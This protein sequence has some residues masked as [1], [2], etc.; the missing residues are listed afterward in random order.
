MEALINA[1]LHANLTAAISAVVLVTLYFW[2]VSIIARRNK[3]LEALS[4][5]DAQLKNRYE[6]IPNILTI[7]KKFMEHE[8]KIF[9]EV[10]KLRESLGQG[11][12]LKSPKDVKDHLVKS[13]KLSQVM[14]TFMARAESYPELKS[15]QNMLQAQQSYNEIEAQILAARRFYNSAVGS[16]RDSVQVFP[17]NILAKL[18]GVKEMP[19]YEVDE[20]SK[21]SVN[22][23]NFL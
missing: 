23:S 16:L 3:V 5:I 2:Y 6:L 22:A 20:A 15:S 10:A 21:A 19:F 7:A 14:G 1:I 13:E 17:G 4:G 12:D 9:S 11:Y 8:G 18:A